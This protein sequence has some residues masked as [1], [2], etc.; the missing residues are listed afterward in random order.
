MGTAALDEDSASLP[1]PFVYAVLTEQSRQ[2]DR[3]VG[4]ARVD[5]QAG[6]STKGQTVKG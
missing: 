3:Q 4:G 6:R 1:D 5:E 2:T